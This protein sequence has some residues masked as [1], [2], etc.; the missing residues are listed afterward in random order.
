MAKADLKCPSCSE[1]TS[2]DLTKPFSFCSNCG[3]KIELA[4]VMPDVSKDKEN[5][6]ANVVKLAETALAAGNFAELLTYAN[7]IL[8]IDG[9]NPV[10]WEYKMKAVYGTATLGDLKCR[11][12]ITCG[13]RAIEANPDPVYAIKIFS[14]FLSACLSHLKFCMQ[15]LQDVEN[16]KRLY[17]AECSLHMMKATELTLAKDVTADCVIRQRDDIL[18]LRLH[19]P[20]QLLAENPVLAQQAGEVAKQFAYVQNALNDR[21]NVYG[22]NFN[23]TALADWRNQLN[24]I[25][26]GL[27]QE[28]QAEIEAGTNMSAEKK[29]GCYIATA[30]YGSYSAPEVIY[31]RMYRDQCLKTS[32]LGRTFI[33]LYYT[34]SPSIA[35]QM[36]GHEKINL[37]VRR[38]LNKWIATILPRLSK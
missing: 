8:E 22:T 28:K 33:R 15:Q 37:F 11:E 18:S 5:E 7:R 12:I 1:I 20:N 30:V 9:G 26:E 4:R 21:F 31:L 36:L 10:G 14:F 34:I 24:K 16:I 17:Q 6:L 25:Q 27:P 23:E 35:K 38:V 32:V 13:G 29:S 19:V 2:I 3:A